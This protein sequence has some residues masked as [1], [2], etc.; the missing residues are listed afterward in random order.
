MLL[1]RNL[2]CNT[3]LLLLAIYISSCANSKKAFYF[4]NQGTGV[5]NS[6]NLAP[7]SLIQSGDI[8]SITVFSLSQESLSIYNTPN[9]TS[10]YSSNQSNTYTYS[11]PGSVSQLGGYLV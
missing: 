2:L 1:M 9:L 6:P 4:A 5:L 8:L 7:A 11:G 10:G 3:L